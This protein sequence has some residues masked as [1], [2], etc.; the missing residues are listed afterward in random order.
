MAGSTA[1]A[2]KVALLGLLNAAAGL[3]GVQVSYTHPGVSV[4]QE[5]IFFLRTILDEVA[6]SLGQQKRRESYIIEVVVTVA[7]DGDDAQAAEERMWALVTEVEN[8]LRPPLGPGG[9]V[10]ATLGGA[11][12]LWAEVEHVEQTPFIEAGQRVSEAIVNVRCRASK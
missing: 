3:D 4:E 2:A 5:S 1:P 11:L 10:S 6:R 8:V 12:N 7:R 9:A